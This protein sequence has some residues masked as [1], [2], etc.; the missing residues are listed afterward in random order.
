MY[1][2]FVYHRCLNRGCGC[3]DIVLAAAAAAMS[4][5]RSSRVD[6]FVTHTPKC[7]SG[8]VGVFVL[9][10]STLCTYRRM[11]GVFFCLGSEG[12]RF[13]VVLEFI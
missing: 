4:C 3:C 9:H 7:S 5:A 10:D 6:M 2:I 13:V 12:K 8:F 1:S 11:P